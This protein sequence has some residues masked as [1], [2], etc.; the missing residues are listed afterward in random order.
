[1]QTLDL[2]LATRPF[3]NNTLLWLGHGLALAVLLVFAVWNV[4]TWIEHRENL[5][6]LRSQVADIDQRFAKL[7]QRDRKAQAQIKGFDLA[8]LRVR[9]AKANEVIRWKAFS[10]TGLFNDLEALQPNDVRMTTV[11]PVF[12]A[13]ERLGAAEAGVDPD[14]VPVSVEGLARDHEAFLELERALLRDAHFVWV[15][16]ER[17]ATDEQSRETVFQLRFL[18]DPT[19]RPAER[20]ATGEDE[21]ADA[22]PDGNAESDEELPADHQGAGEPEPEDGAGRTVAEAR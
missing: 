8:S 7:D 11:H 10:W 14:T 22:G 16:P 2:N 17:T 13:R 12:R 5:A 19:A 21:P 18:Y 6:D 9:A 3:R 4:R 1:M 20:L 15:E